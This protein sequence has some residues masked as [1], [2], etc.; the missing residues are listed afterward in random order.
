MKRIGLLCVALLAACSGGGGETIA[1]TSP[2]QTLRDQ[3]VV[4]F[5]ING[6][7]D[8]DLLTVEKDGTIVA[9]LE[10]TGGDPVDTT[11]LRK[12][13]KIDAKVAEAIAAYVDQ[14]IA[15]ASE[16]RL[17]VVDSQ[18]ATVTVTVFE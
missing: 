13:T 12:G 10:S 18:G 8:P 9:S 5:D 17:D 14:S 15:L 1:A 4:Q 7:E 2:P 3:I 11:D 16:T 6:D